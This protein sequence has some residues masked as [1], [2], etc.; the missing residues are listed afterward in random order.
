MRPIN[1]EV[2]ERVEEGNGVVT[3]RFDRSFDVSPGEFGMFWVRGVDEIPMSFAY[4]DGITVRGVGEATNAM[5]DMREGDT[6]GVRGPFGTPFDVPGGGEDIVIVGGGTGMA[7]VALLTETAAETGAEVT[8]LIGAATADELVFEDRL[9]S[10]ADVR[11]ATEDGS[12]G[13]E[14]LVTGLLDEVVEEKGAP[15]N[16]ASCGPELMMSAVL[17]RFD[18]RPS[19]VQMCLERYMKCGVGICGSCC[20]DDSG[21]PVCSDGPV[22]RGDELRNGEFGVYH[23]DAAGRKEYF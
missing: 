3:L 13:Y 12:A 5:L 22:Y 11:V 7:P 16:V 18:G 9:S 17:E 4:S 2:V 15:S 19:D 10:V 23:R 1:L 21:S 14:G 8:T 20:V 6:L